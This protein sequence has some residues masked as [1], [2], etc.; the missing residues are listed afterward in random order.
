MWDPSSLTRNGTKVPCIERW[1]LNHWTTGK[2]QDRIFRKHFA[3]RNLD[4]VLLIY[5]P[6][7][8]RTNPTDRLRDEPILDKE[9]KLSKKTMISPGHCVFVLSSEELA[10][11]PQAVSVADAC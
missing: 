11:L 3:P 2:P 7:P 5:V 4:G 8:M 6:P 1:I 10:H 9:S